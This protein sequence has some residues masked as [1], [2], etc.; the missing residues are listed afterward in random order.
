M[1]DL[2]PYLSAAQ[3][4][5]ASAFRFCS[6]RALGGAVENVF[7]NTAEGAELLKAAAL[8]TNA[9]T[10]EF[11]RRAKEKW[12]RNFNKTNFFADVA[13]ARR[14]MGAAIP[15]KYLLTTNGT[16]RPVVANA[17]TMMES[18][19]VRYNLFSCRPEL[20]AAPPWGGPSG[21]WTDHE[22]TK[23]AEWCQRKELHIATN[24]AAEAVQA[25]AM[26]RS[27]HPV[28]DY[29][30]GLRHDGKMRLCNWL[31]RYAG[32]DDTELIREIGVRWMIS[33]VAR[34][35]RPACQADYMLVL[36]GSEGIRKSSALRVLGDPWFTDDVSDIGNG[37]EAA[38]NIQ[39]YW[40][41]E[42]KELASFR[43]SEWTQILGWL[44]RRED[45]FRPPYG[46]RVAEFPRQ[47][48]FAGSTNQQQWIT[49]EHGTRRFWPISVEKI[50][51][52]AFERDRDQLWAEAYKYFQ[53]GEPWH[54]GED[55]IGAAQDAQRQRR[56]TDPWA[57]M[58]TRWCKSP[59]PRSVGTAISSTS[60]QVYPDEV[61]EHCIGL[62]P[63]QM[64]GGEGERVASI[65]RAIGYLRNED[66]DYAKE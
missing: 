57:R 66:G 6:T 22:D 32:S 21:K 8:A 1:P 62:L 37:H 58:I 55:M 7:P 9:E 49:G 15:S 63:S 56:L 31:Y 12:G 20:T 53:K 29:L 50:D 19:P 43:R 35:M 42:L 54:L 3:E 61:L 46:R 4:E 23:A 39:G 45:K 59:Y 52:A 14:A 51:L 34:V 16:L 27:Y 25:V 11:S 17:I 18:L 65:L 10:R 5:V 60:G 64:R 28:R 33:G 24:I 26:E 41:V 47:S 48:I 40:I 36:E 30:N 44:D 38:I 13:D 2:N